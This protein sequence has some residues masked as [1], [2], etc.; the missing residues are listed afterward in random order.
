MLYKIL[1]VITRVLLK[2]VYGLEVKGYEN[3]PKKGPYII[4]PN[5]TNL[6]DPP[7]VGA[8]VKSSVYYMAKQELFKI[9]IFNLLIKKLNAFPIKREKTDIKSL[10]TAQ[11]LLK[12]GKIIAIFPQGRRKKFNDISTEKEGVGF[13][14]KLTSSPVIPTF[15]DGTYDFPK[16]R[17]IKVIFGKPIYPDNL[18]KTT[19][20]KMTIEEIKKLKTIT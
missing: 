12:E 9:P 11:K 14:S 18:D 19:I 16:I 8:S 7:V 13:L 15:I 2:L 6:V 20:T 17:K 10:R 1:W 3:L 4:A 5:H